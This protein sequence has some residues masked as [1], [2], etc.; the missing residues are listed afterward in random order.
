MS[1]VKFRQVSTQFI[2]ALGE[3]TASSG[4][5]AERWGLWPVDPGPRGVRLHN[6]DKVQAA[7]GVTPAGWSLTSPFWIEE[8]GLVMEA[9]VF[10]LPAGRYLV[11]GDREVTTMLTVHA[12]DAETG[13]SRWELHRGTLHDVTHLPCRSAC[14]TPVADDV[15][16]SAKL[17][18]AQSFPVTPGAEMPAAV[19]CDKQ[20]YW[21]IFVIGMA[22]SDDEE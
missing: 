11:T 17:F 12:P 3:P 1:S 10:P 13:E 15:V 8:H 2:A 22:V 6:V 7:G 9:P 21:V 4:S 14:Y 16:P 5:G 19:Q 20:D 18:P